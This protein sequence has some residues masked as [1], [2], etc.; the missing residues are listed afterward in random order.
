M[1]VAQYE[2]DILPSTSSSPPSQIVS[3][4]LTYTAKLH[5][6]GSSRPS[7]VT[8]TTSKA[9]PIVPSDTRSSSTQDHRSQVSFANRLV[10]LPGSKGTNSAHAPQLRPG[11]TLST[12][13]PSPHTILPPPSPLPTA[14]DLE[15]Q[16]PAL[17][18]LQ[19]PTTIR[20]GG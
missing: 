12:S 14:V 15:A 6:Y 20:Q 18:V 3:R 10:C 17:E 16:I 9:I 2:L 4:P 19:T 11:R 5:A 7:Q 13:N 8:T 1:S